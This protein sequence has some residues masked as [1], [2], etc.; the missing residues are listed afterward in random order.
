LV[1]APVAVVAVG[2]AAGFGAVGSIEPVV[3]E[4]FRMT[5]VRVG[6]G[7]IGEFVGGTVVNTGV[8]TGSES[9]AWAMVGSAVAVG[10][11]QAV[12]KAA[13]STPINPSRRIRLLTLNIG[14]SQEWLTESELT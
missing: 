1:Q 13:N 3:G 10:A 6:L 12:S 7:G 2:W 9:V 14:P 5:A 8:F 11:L 4:D